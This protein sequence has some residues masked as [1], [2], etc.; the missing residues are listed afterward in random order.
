M[1]TA[2]VQKQGSELHARPQTVKS[3]YNLTG[4]SP[5][6]NVNSV[7]SSV[8]V[9]T[10]NSETLFSLVKVIREQVE[11]TEL[12][13]QLSATVQQ[14]EQTRGTPEFTSSFQSFIALAAN[15]MTIVLPFIP[16][17]TQ[18]LK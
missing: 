12:R 14:M 18:L 11:G 4:A 16:A 9:L 5:Q 13:D 3:V 6:V 17:L 7:D 2:Y 1:I 10:V 15:C 8:N